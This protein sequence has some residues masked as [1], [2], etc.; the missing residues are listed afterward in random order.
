MS[1]E[2]TRRLKGLDEALAAAV[3]TL[4]QGE[5]PEDLEGLAEKILAEFQALNLAVNGETGGAPLT[6]SLLYTITGLTTLCL[7]YAV[8]G[9]GD[10]ASRAELLALGWKITT[11]WDAVLAGDVADVCAHVEHEA[12]SRLGGE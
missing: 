3:L 6:R 11:A 5:T 8:S 12:A 4:M 2:I 10:E 1:E 9:R 7:D